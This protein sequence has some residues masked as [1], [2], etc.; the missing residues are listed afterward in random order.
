MQFTHSDTTKLD[1]VLISAME[2]LLPLNVPHPC[3]IVV[4]H[5]TPT[6]AT[7]NAEHPARI[8]GSLSDGR[9]Y[10][11]DWITPLTRGSRT[12]VYVRAEQPRTPAPSDDP[13]SSEKLLWDAGTGAF[14]NKPHRFFLAIAQALEAKGE[15]SRAMYWLYQNFSSLRG[16]M[17]EALE[18]GFGLD[19]LKQLNIEPSTYPKVSNGF[20]S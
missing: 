14:Y 10:R 17:D 6:E 8:H 9:H 20:E 18:N 12:T 5:V 13:T 7:A 4:S 3:D 11:V 2:S 15:D 19:R 1:A 16:S